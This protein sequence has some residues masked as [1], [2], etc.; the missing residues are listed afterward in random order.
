[1]PDSGHWLTASMINAVVQQPS[2]STASDWRQVLLHFLEVLDS[3]DRLIKITEAASEHSAMKEEG[4][5]EHLDAVRQQLLKAFQT[6]DVTFFDTVGKPFDP[7]HHEAVEVIRRQDVADG[8]IIEELLRGGEWRGDL[9]RF[10]KVV[11]ARKS[12]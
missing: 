12:N 10:A 4:W 5:Y 3:L 1:M 7:A 11:V 8:I 2:S 6:A 9:L